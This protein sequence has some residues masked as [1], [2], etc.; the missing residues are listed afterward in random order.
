MLNDTSANPCLPWQNLGQP[1]PSSTEDLG[2][3][4]CLTCH[5]CDGFQ[6][7]KPGIP[8][9]VYSKHWKYIIFR[10]LNC[11][12]SSRKSSS[13]TSVDIEE[14]LSYFSLPNA[15]K[16]RSVSESPVVGSR[17]IVAM[18]ALPLGP[19]PSRKHLW[20]SANWEK[21][22]C[23]FVAALKCQCFSCI[24]L[25]RNIFPHYVKSEVNVYCSVKTES[26]MKGN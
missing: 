8:S 13:L 19:L 12:G 7:L 10:L 3:R 4:T 11:K 18:Q 2:L 21:V 17:A 16:Y 5:W 22:K 26:Q 15:Q 25:K 23:S 6:T 1:K 20:S 24:F 14:A 9:I